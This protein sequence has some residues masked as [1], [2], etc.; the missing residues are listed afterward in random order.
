MARNVLAQIDSFLAEPK[1]IFLID[2]LGAFLT[3]FFLV[4][5]LTPFSASF[6]MP[7]NVLYILSA[8]AGL[9][10][11]YSLGCYFL[12]IRNWRSN[13]A[14]ISLANLLYCLLTA[15]LIVY[16]YSSLTILG[17]LYFTLEISTIM[18]LVYYERQLLSQ[19]TGQ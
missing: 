1:R 14:A 11:L 10:M 13:V 18:I 7:V 16:Y 8:I 2:G 15:S 4:A 12:P 9:L 5:I 19:R 17:A 6:G 3:A